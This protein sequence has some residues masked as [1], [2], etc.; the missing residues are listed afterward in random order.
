M[1]DNILDRAD[2]VPLFLEELTKAVLEGALG[3]ED[4]NRHGLIGAAPG[5]DIPMTLQA[6]LLRGLIA[7]RPRARWRRSP[8]PSAGNSA[9]RF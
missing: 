8:R 3:R 5:A 2:G 4:D 1:L 6:S 7:I 9:I